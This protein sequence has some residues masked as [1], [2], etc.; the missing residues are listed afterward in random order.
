[1]VPIGPYHNFSVQR[2][3]QI[4]HCFGLFYKPSTTIMDSNTNSFRHRTIPPVIVT[5]FR[6]NQ[7]LSGTRPHKGK[8]LVDEQ[9]ELLCR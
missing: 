2:Q 3:S 1:M 7:H 4:F 8:A 5:S 6:L 9:D